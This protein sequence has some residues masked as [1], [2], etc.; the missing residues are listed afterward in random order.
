MSEIEATI[1][2]DEEVA[3]LNAYQERGYMHPFTCP[4]HADCPSRNLK[5]TPEGWVCACGDYTQNWAHDFM[6]AHGQRVLDGWTMTLGTWREPTLTPPII[7]GE[8]DE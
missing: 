7:M 5:A 3:R 4:G 2:T 8:T 6:F 1:W